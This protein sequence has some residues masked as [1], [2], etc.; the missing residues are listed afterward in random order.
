ML[1][2]MSYLVEIDIDHVDEM[3]DDANVLP[4][5][6][7]EVKSKHQRRCTSSA[8]DFFYESDGKTKAVCKKCGKKYLTNSKKKKKQGH[9]T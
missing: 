8:W 1:E 4:S 6:T 2:N 7:S 5:E 9:Q 3:S